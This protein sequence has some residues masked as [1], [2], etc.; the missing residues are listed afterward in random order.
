[1]FQ[2]RFA[3]GLAITVD[4]FDIQIEG[5]HLDLGVRTTPGRRATGQNDPRLA[6]AI[7][8]NP[9]HR[10][11]V[12]RHGHVDGPQRNIGTLSTTGYDVNIG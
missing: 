5:H 12:G 2:P 11:V 7:Q 1:V 4:Y 9:G 8:R 10:A 6:V 3:P